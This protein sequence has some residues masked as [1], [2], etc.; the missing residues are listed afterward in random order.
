M[1]RY[2]IL[3]L[4]KPRLEVGPQQKNRLFCLVSGNQRDPTKAKTTRGAN[5]GEET[6][7]DKTGHLGVSQKDAGFSCWFH[8]QRHHSGTFF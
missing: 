7:T 8:L 4:L 2:A 3:L 1:G 6:G 5:S